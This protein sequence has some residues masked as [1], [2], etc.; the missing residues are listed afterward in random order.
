M[1]QQLTLA[2]HCRKIAALGGRK[3]SEKKTAACRENARKP[4]RSRLKS[5][6]LES[7]K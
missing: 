3:K 5:N 2:E 6:S 1:D 4:R 7:K